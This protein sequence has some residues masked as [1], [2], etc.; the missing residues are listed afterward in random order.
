MAGAVTV[1]RSSGVARVTVLDVGQGDAILVEGSRGGRLL[2]DGGPDPTR[3]LVVLDGRIP[4]W[5][6]RIDAVILT[7]PHE[8]HVAGLARL[9]AR[10][11][12]GR[13]F[14]PGMRGPG[15]GYA[16]WLR[17]LNGSAAPIRMRLAAG[18]ALAVDE[19][20]LHVLWPIRGRVPATPPDGGTG[21]NNVSIV[22]LGS[23]STYRFL[24][25]GD[26]EEAIDPSL[27]SEGVP[28]PGP[29]QGRAPREPD[30][31]DRRRSSTRSGPVSRSR[32]PAPATRTA[33]RRG[34]PSSDW[35][36]P[37]PASSAP[38]STAAWR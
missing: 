35:P 13:V 14:E 37:V 7:H 29:A 12:V 20:A 38:T 9:L 26:V 25:A 36:R 33:T 18:D 27:L 2:I 24:L 15:P 8:D 16:E 17:R 4:P 11:R 19:I 6:R 31:D 5:D 10:Y 34:R 23:V 3:L 32:R 22:L 21:I 30:G 1:S 28:A